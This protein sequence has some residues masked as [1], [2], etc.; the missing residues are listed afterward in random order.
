LL[1]ASRWEGAAGVVVDVPVERQPPRRCLAHVPRTPPPGLPYGVAAVVSRRS[2]ATCRRSGEHHRGRNFELAKIMVTAAAAEGNRQ[3]RPSRCRPGSSG[4]EGSP[5]WPPLPGF[6]RSSKLEVCITLDDGWADGEIGVVFVDRII[7]STQSPRLAPV[8]LEESIWGAATP[9]GDVGGSSST[10]PCIPFPSPPAPL[11]PCSDL[12]RGRWP[13][14]HL[15]QI[16]ER[17]GS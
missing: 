12:L 17:E 14:H 11:P 10:C 16:L 4:T 6:L 5:R 13:P 15:S 3:R 7:P 1:G 8:P 9:A 2:G